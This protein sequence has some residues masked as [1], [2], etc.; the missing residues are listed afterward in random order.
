MEKV[1]ATICR[2]CDC[3]KELADLAK[4]DQELREIDES[5]QKVLTTIY[6]KSNCVKE[7]ANLDSKTRAFRAF[8]NQPKVRVKKVSY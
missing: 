2:K 7:L 6:H 8:Q 3:V 5:I 1:F 4:Y